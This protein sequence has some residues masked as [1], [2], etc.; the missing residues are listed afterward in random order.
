MLCAAPVL[1][2]SETGN[3]FGD[4]L[5]QREKL[6]QLPAA[7]QVQPVSGTAR[8]QSADARPGLRSLADFGDAL[9]GTDRVLPVEFSAD[10]LLNEPLVD[11]V[12][13]GNKTIASPAILQHI[14]TRPG[15]PPA[16]RQVQEDVAELYRLRWFITVRPIYRQTS[17][18]P[19]L[20]FQVT[21]RPIVRSV[22]FIGN[23]KI[24][25]GELQAH[26]GL[27]T[28]SGFD[29]AANRESVQRIMSL[30]REKGYRFAKVELSKGGNPED[31]DVIFV[32][33]EGPKVR[34][35]DINFKGNSFVSGPVLQTKLST[36]HTWA[37][38]IGGTYDPELVK[39]DVFTLKQYYTNLGFFEVEV[40]AEE[41]FFEKNGYVVVTFKINEGPRY[42]V[43][44]IETTGN[45]VVATDRL[46]HKLNL[47]EGEYFN[48]R[49]LR[50]DIS[51]MKDRYDEL[52]R[53]FAKVEPVPQFRAD[54]PGWVDL[55]YQIDE[56]MPRLVGTINVHIRGDYPHTQEEVVLQMMH[57]FVKPGQLANGKALQM[58]QQRINGSQLFERTDPPT[59]DIRPVEGREYLPPRVQRAQN[60]QSQDERGAIWQEIWDETSQETPLPPLRGFGH[61]VS[62]VGRVALPAAAPAVQPAPAPAAR[63]PRPGTIQLPAAVEPNTQQLPGLIPPS[64]EAPPAGRQQSAVQQEQHSHNTVAVARFNPDDVFSVVGEDSA[65]IAEEELIYRSQSPDWTYRGQSLNSWGLPVP[66]DNLITNSPQG[67][68]FG[69]ALRDPAPGFVDVNVDVTEGRTGRLMFGV[70]VN[71]NAGVVGSLV[72]Q[73]DNFDILRVPTSW[74]DFANG[75]AF[76]GAGQ[77]FRIEAVPGV[78]V[79]RYAVSWQ[80]PYFMRSDYSLGLSGFYYN[81]F[82]TDWTEDRLGGRISVGRILD[83]YWSAGVSVRLEDVTVRGIRNIA[84]APQQLLDVQGHNLLSTVGVTATYDR[85]D[86]A[87]MPSRG[88]FVEGSY[89]QAFGEYSYPRGE[90]TAG[91]YFTLYER[92]DGYGK[93]ILSFRGQ[94]GITG[95]DTPIFEKFY[96]GGYSSF[97]GFAFRG[98]S[99]RYLDYTIGGDWMALGTVEYM[100][101]ITASDNIQAVVFSDMGTVEE[102]IGFDQFRITAGFGLRLMI[103]AMGPAPLA[104]DFAWPIMSEAQDTERVFSFYI[105]FTR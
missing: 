90:L 72:L 45:E 14:K 102:K 35:W 52:G 30:Y 34:V 22:Q 11:V 87:F 64:D 10:E 38:I 78:Q 98:V 53:L 61:S 24:K 101:P 50:Q 25:T 49:F 27:R 26:V 47:E 12:I 37:W 99:P 31:R 80:D 54:E 91:Q 104:F 6:G 5:R 32:I 63:L 19:I 20:V 96:A 100:V 75:T 8:V 55:V 105:G 69:D 95:S 77:S 56:D 97:R 28:G 33:E 81:R 82:F 65:I 42:R 15:R 76:R 85:R 17:E 51:A 16:P 86:S 36:K 2:Q 94:L 79:S 18:G 88:F 66:Q 59:F 89:E 7:E 60:E 23:K 62:P 68:P 3:A 44:T 70:G 67:D 74:A 57:R 48:A 1:A 21:E 92:P 46:L 40:E 58:A 83:Q 4:Y 13:E 43:G 9:P 41:E 39:N 84:F 73:E 29:V 103:P 71:S 93:H